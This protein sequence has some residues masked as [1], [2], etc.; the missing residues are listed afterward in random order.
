MAER[1]P[2]VNILVSVL[3]LVLQTLTDSAFRGDVREMEVSRART[4]Y[5]IAF[6]EWMESSTVAGD[7]AKA[8]AVAT[9]ARADVEQSIALNPS[10]VPAHVLRNRILFNLFSQGAL[11]PG[12]ALPLMRE[13]F[14]AAKKLAPDD[15][16]VKV[17]EATFLYYGP[18]HDL[19]GGRAMVRKAIDGLAA[20]APKDADAATWLPIV[21]SWY[22]IMFLGEGE[23][24]QAQVAFSEALKVRPDY[25]YVKTAMLPMTQVVDVGTAPQ[26]SEWTPLLTDGEGDG[27]MPGLPDLR[28]VQWHADGDRVWFRFELAGAPDPAHVGVNLALDTDGDPQTGHNWW[29][30]NTA[31]RYDRLVTSWVAR[32][33]DGR[34]RGSVGVADADDAAGGR[35][36]TSPAGTVLFALDAH[37]F[38]LGVQRDALAPNMRVVATVGSNIMWND[39]AP[40]EGAVELKL[41][42]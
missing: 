14:E 29:A 9:R 4:L 11:K 15:P 17:I 35:Y 7:S 23:M 28:D 38:Y 1:R 42:P 24:E 39:V 37:A 10:V 32:G 34:Y 20:R 25:T 16:L 13:S 2:A 12:E 26:F 36:V 5:T 21:W 22:G 18:Q 8:I 33:K 3:L 40:E 41:A 6:S 31:F 30:G 27:R 19:G